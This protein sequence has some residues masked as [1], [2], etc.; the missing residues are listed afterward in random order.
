M[1]GEGI[2]MRF[3]RDDPEGMVTG[4]GV[5]LMAQLKCINTNAHRMGNNNKELEAILCQT[6]TC[7]C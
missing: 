1:K 2:K 5:R 7:P 4:L 6:M 3:T